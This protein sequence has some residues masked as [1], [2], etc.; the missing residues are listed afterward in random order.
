MGGITV[1]VLATQDQSQVVVYAEGDFLHKGGPMTGKEVFDLLEN[2][3]G[4]LEHVEYK[5]VTAEQMQ[6]PLTALYGPGNWGP[7]DC[8]QDS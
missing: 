6:K 4:A 1:N 8:F 2:T 5:E 7:D 3:L